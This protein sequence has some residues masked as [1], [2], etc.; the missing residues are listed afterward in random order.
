MEK[1]GLY[2]DTF[3]IPFPIEN[4]FDVIIRFYSARPITVKKTRLVASSPP[5]YMK[6]EGGGTLGNGINM[7]HEIYVELRPVPNGTSIA[8]KYQM[9]S[10]GGGFPGELFKSEVVSLQNLLRSFYEHPQYLFDT[11]T[12]AEIAGRYEEAATIWEK[13]GNHEKAGKAR[14]KAK[15]QTIKHINVDMNS[16][17]DQLRAGGLVSVYKCPNCGASIKISGTTS[18]NKLSTCEY[19]GTVLQTDDIVKFIQDIL[20]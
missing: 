3:D 18:V 16:L 10:M 11:A 6:F 5:S 13:L 14:D 8:F 2:S 4:A 17:L 15:S 20:S 7:K 1:F 12:K 9:N 19:C